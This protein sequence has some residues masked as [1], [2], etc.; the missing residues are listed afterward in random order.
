MRPSDPDFYFGVGS[1]GKTHSPERS[2]ELAIGRALSE[3]II[4]ARGS[5]PYDIKFKEKGEDGTVSLEVMK[6]GRA[7][8]TIRGVMVLR[9][10]KCKAS[11][12]GFEQDTLFVLIRL[13]TSA[14]EW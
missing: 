3:I 5:N 13:P 7:V 2:R 4:Q 11:K 10:E 8:R 6:E 14:I 9:E 1:C 12:H